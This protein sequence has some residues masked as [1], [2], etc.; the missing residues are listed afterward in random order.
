ML[1]SPQ[2]SAPASVDE[3][4]IDTDLVES[5]QVHTTPRSEAQVFPQAN[6]SCRVKG[7]MGTREQMLKEALEYGVGKGRRT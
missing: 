2:K 6:L 7:R 1:S 3:E 5:T 4:N